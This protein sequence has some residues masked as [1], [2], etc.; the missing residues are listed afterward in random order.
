MFGPV[1][2]A[3]RAWTRFVTFDPER[4]YLDEAIDRLDL[5]RRQREIDGG[6]FRRRTSFY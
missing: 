4:A 2:K 3:Q 1:K 6:L 5:E